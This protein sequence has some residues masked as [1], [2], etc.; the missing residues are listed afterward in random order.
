M[1]LTT[2]NSKIKKLALSLVPEGKLPVAVFPH[3][4]TSRTRK[5]VC[6]IFAEDE[7]IMEKN[8]VLTRFQFHSYFTS[9]FSVNIILPKTTVSIQ[10]A[11]LNTFRQI[12]LLVKCLI[13]SLLLF[14]QFVFV[15][16]GKKIID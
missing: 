9:C 12:K 4:H 13:V 7:S 1:K 16:F 8:S 15:F 11:V 2:G 5:A 3:F 10:K 14:R 6:V